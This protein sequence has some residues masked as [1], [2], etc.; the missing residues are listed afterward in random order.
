MRPARNRTIESAFF[1]LLTVGLATDAVRQDAN[2]TAV[3][4]GATAL[5]LVYYGADLR[6]IELA[7]WISMRFRRPQQE[8]GDDDREDPDDGG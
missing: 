7:D 5:L 2:A 6:E 4:F 3:F 1:A 8:R